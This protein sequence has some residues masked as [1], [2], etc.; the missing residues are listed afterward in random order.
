MSQCRRTRRVPL[1]DFDFRL[2]VTQCN[3]RFDFELYVLFHNNYA[4]QDPYSA[5][6]RFVLTHVA[7]TSDAELTEFRSV[8]H[9]GRPLHVVSR[10]TLGLTRPQSN[11]DIQ[12]DNLN[13]LRPITH[14]TSFAKRT[15]FC[16]GSFDLDTVS[17]A[18]RYRRMWLALPL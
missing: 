16:K 6:S 2:A 5:L 7:S 8:L 1:P 3:V 12:T 4:Q 13:L 18:C 10:A 11:E 14:V 15:R 9:V 17:S